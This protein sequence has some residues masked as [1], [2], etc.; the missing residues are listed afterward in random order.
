MSNPFF[1]RHIS[2]VVGIAL[3][4]IACV[5]SAWVGYAL[6]KRYRST[7]TDFY[8]HSVNSVYSKIDSL[9]S[10]VLDETEKIDKFNN[11]S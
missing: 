10:D 3:I 4:V 5:L 1:N 7:I 8:T 6:A 2:A 9:Q 11:N